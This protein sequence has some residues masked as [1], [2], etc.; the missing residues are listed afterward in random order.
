MG[1]EE[2]S[3]PL[4]DSDDGDGDDQDPHGSHAGSSSDAETSKPSKREKAKKSSSSSG[5]RVELRS[6]LLPDTAVYRLHG[7]LPLQ[8]RLASLK[9]FSAVPSA[10]SPDA[11]ASS[12]LLCTSVASRGLDLPLVRAVV[13]YDLPTESGATEYVHRVGR[14]A[15]AGKG[16]EAWSFVAPSEAEWVKWVQAKMRGDTAEE[17]AKPTDGEGSVMLDGV[18]MENVLKKGFGGKG[19][20][21]EERAT[22]V[23]LSF[24]RWVLRDKQVR[25]RFDDKCNVLG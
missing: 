5:E 14:T 24:E 22:E 2:Q 21:Y 12:I 3:G 8:T 15:R 25:R 9:G 16:G 19:N 4:S 17:K 6:A 10:K 23:Q 13:Q 18:S 11:P 1:D 20:E 7:S